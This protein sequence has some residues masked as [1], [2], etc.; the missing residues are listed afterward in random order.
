MPKQIEKPLIGIVGGEGKMGEWFRSFFNNLGL[1]VIISDINTQ[2]TNI[3]LS[4]K[5]D[6][7]L[8]SVPIR[9]AVEVIKEI[10]G[11]V[12]KDA[13]LCDIISLKTEP[14][15]AMAMAHSGV[16]GMHPLFGP[17]FQDMKG[18]K[19][20]FCPMQAK[21]NQWVDFLKD[22]F[23][24]NGAEVIE[25]SPKQH[26][27]Q[28]AIV[29]ALTHFV[30]VNLAQTFFAQKFNPNSS[31][32]TPVFRLQSLIIGRVLSTDPQLCC[33]IEMENPYFPKV[34]ARFEQQ[35]KSSAKDVIG[36]NRKSFV[37]KIEKVSAV[38]DD[39]IKI[40]QS[41]STQ[42]LQLVD[43]QPIKAKKASSIS[44]LKQQGAK[45]GFLGPQGTFSHQ[46]ATNLFPNTNKLIPFNAIRE[47]FEAVN[48]QTIDF[49]VV[50]AENT[51][52]GIV[53]ETINS[54][55]EYP[56][57]VSGSFEL[58]IHH[59][60]LSRLKD[61]KDLQIIKTHKQALLQCEK[62]LRENLPQIKTEVSL[63]TTSAIEETKDKYTGFI[64][65]FS[66][67][68]VYGLN[69]LAKDIEDAKGNVTKF[70]IITNVLNKAIQ[71]KLGNNKTLLLLAV[72][73]RVGVLRDILQ[74]FANNG[75]NLSSLHSVPSK[76]QPWDYFFFMEVDNHYQS[77]AIKKTLKDIAKYC[78]V[79]REI[80]AG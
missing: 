65:P 39:F 46:A 40:S 11:V 25:M 14:V 74:V 15:Q 71:Q 75:L 52:G 30:N 58:G 34:L 35:I 48:N 27:L 62:F 16:L 61:K 1:K 68:K 10:R 20:V 24:K 73:N 45:V 44:H 19:I 13:L 41:K 17:L 57:K 33:D 66:A 4:K 18:Q 29:Q 64:A 5:A 37:K 43:N 9:K 56:L 8:V 54:L 47:I 26:D 50:P 21:S 60:L 63:S 12:R 7:V 53:P 31:F 55:I 72:Y 78:T 23:I 76:L 28:M 38:L 2:L 3:E 67:A 49:G 22:I 77:L 79:I 36:K 80:G 42:V 6:I 70:Y 59:C 51:L 69:V 32:L